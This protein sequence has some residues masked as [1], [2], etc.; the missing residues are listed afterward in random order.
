[1]LLFWF[2]SSPPYT[3]S[4]FVHGIVFSKDEGVLGTVDGVDFACYTHT[5]NEFLKNPDRKIENRSMWS[6]ETTWCVEIP[7]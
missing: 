7:F 1:M 2:P 5:T 6:I 3:K 4:F